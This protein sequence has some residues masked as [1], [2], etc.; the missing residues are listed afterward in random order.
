MGDPEDMSGFVHAIHDSTI[1]PS[2]VPPPKFM[3]PADRADEPGYTKV[4]RDSVEALVNSIANAEEIFSYFCGRDD[5]DTD[6]G[7]D[8]GAEDDDGGVI[9]LCES[10]SD[11]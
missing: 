4:L 5:D 7:T 9:D 8:D 10:G 11:E 6:D 1:A 3:D 2:L